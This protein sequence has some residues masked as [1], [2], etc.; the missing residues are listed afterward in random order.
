MISESRSVGSAAFARSTVEQILESAHAK[1]A[2]ETANYLLINGKLDKY[3]YAIDV[4]QLATSTVSIYFNGKRTCEE[5]KDR[6][7]GY[8]SLLEQY[9][10]RCLS[11]GDIYSSDSLIYKNFIRLEQ[12][13]G[14]E[15]KAL[16]DSVM[17]LYVAVSMRAK[18]TDFI[19]MTDAI[20]EFLV[21][22]RTTVNDNYY[23]LYNYVMLRC[24]YFKPVI[25]Q[26]KS[27]EQIL[28][29]ALKKWMVSAAHYIT[30]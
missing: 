27:K 25:F 21:N 4:I 3:I 28:G 6:L 24:N 20:N 18:I 12:S 1:N 22:L 5:L 17:D 26:A 9:S 7:K 10:K 29:G 15:I 2:S 16:F 19:A 30:I 23:V 8:K 14:D 11:K 13:I